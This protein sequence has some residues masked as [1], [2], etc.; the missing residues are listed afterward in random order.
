MTAEEQGA[1]HIRH[2]IMRVK[3]ASEALHP[4]RRRSG[5][6]YSA[7]ALLSVSD[8]L[9]ALQTLEGPEVDVPGLKVDDDS[10]E[11]RK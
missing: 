2:A 1:E 4:I 8:L 11:K 5:R 10:E 6:V 7:H 3:L 9:L